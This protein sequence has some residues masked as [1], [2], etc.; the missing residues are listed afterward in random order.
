MAARISAAPPAM[1]SPASARPRASGCGSG[2]ASPAGDVA[3][4]VDRHHLGAEREH[5][6]REGREGA[7]RHLAAALEGREE[8]TL[9]GG[10]ALGRRMVELTH[11]G[12]GGVVGAADLDRDRPLRHR[13]QEAIERQ[14]LGDVALEAQPLDAG[15]G[16][17]DRVV[18]ALL[19]P[20]HPRRHVAAQVDELEVGAIA[21]EQRAPSQAAG[22]DPAA[23]RQ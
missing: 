7:H 17:D 11:P 8:G 1:S 9:G 15:R 21:G 6:A 23:G 10:R 3:A 19:D 18:L 4:A 22:A 12:A 2:A 20:A 16:E 5:L 13:R 14:K